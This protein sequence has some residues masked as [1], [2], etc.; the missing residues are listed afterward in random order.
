MTKQQRKHDYNLTLQQLMPKNN[1]FYEIPTLHRGAYS[2]IIF[3]IEAVLLY[4]GQ[5]LSVKSMDFEL[6]S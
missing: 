3:F 5:S 4:D 1:L 2:K 6:F